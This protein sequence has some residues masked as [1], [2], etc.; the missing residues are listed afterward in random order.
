M[1]DFNPQRLN[2]ARRRRALTLTKLSSLSGISTRSLSNYEAGKQLPAKASVEILSRALRV[3]VGFFEKESAAV[4][5][6]E[7]VSFRKLSKT[8]IASRD[9]VLADASLAIEFFQIIERRFKLP[10]P[11]VPKLDNVSPDRAAD[12]VRKMWSLK[13]LPISNMIHLVES[14]GVRV[15]VLNDE[16]CEID[17]FCL[18]WNNVPYIFLNTSRSAERQRFDLAHELGH[19]VLHGDQEME[20][21]TSKLRES[22]ANQ[23]ASSF[24]MPSDVV[25]RQGMRGASKKRILAAKH[26]WKV[27]AMAMTQRIHELGLLS[28]WQ[29]RRT[30][31]ELSC[32]GY[33]S[34]EPSGVIAEQSQLLRKVMFGCA[35]KVGVR[36]AA[37]MMNLPESDVTKFVKGL[38]PVLV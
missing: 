21:S 29:Y 23:F 15:L 35:N 38:V 26:Y 20:A 1:A 8:S 27:S 14:K 2:M 13:N 36:E 25:N 31:M 9:A 34:S 3:P 18:R 22:E 7:T 16:F 24:L 17:A 6:V 37:I 10:S 30:C 11:D 5:P 33:R 32:E 4:I 19:L 28:D 12:M